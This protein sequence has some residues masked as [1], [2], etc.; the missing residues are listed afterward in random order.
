MV[1]ALQFWLLN[2]LLRNLPLQIFHSIL[3]L[4]RSIWTWHA[5]LVWCHCLHPLAIFLLLCPC[6]FILHIPRFVHIDLRWDQSQTMIVDLNV[7]LQLFFNFFLLLFYFLLFSFFSSSFT[8]FSCFLLTLSLSSVFVFHRLIPAVS[9][10]LP[11]LGIHR[12]HMPMEHPRTMWRV[13]SKSLLHVLTLVCTH[14]ILRV[15]MIESHWDIESL[16]FHIS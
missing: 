14:D 2:F 3:V 13:F 11:S 1:I 9:G 15:C 5:H 6:V 8:C 12:L 16:L 7:F 4:C 10:S